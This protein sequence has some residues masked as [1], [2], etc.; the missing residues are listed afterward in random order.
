M[1][2]S[3]FEGYAFKMLFAFI[4]LLGVLA[5]ALWLVRRFGRE[6]PT[7]AGG[8]GRPARLSVIDAANVDGRR[9]LVLIRRDNL[10]HLVLIGGPSDVLIEPNIAPAGA[11]PREVPPPRHV[12]TGDTLRRAVPLGEG[13][14]WP[15]Q[16]ERGPRPEPLPRPEPQPVRPPPPATEPA[17]HWPPREPEFPQSPRTDPPRDLRG[18]IDPLSGLSEELGRAASASEPEA[19]EPPVWLTRRREPRLRHASSV[20]TPP[21]PAP[22]TDAKLGPSADQNNLAN[23]A[24]RL[25]A[26]MRRPNRKE[27]TSAPPAAPKM[28]K[29]E[30]EGEE[31]VESSSAQDSSP[32]PRASPSL[33]TVKSPRE[34]TK[35]GRN[36]GR[37]APQ[38]SLYDS[39][40]QEMASLSGRSGSKT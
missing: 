40:E 35:P 33:D 10:Q 9:K 23:T 32:A 29:P 38:K 18:R 34:E 39:L 27:G 7:N 20:V 37:P 25:E 21:I 14:M 13:N 28:E 4:V 6:R 19:S 5:L 36:E 3:L 11:T 15:L 16:P 1:L 17:A 24:Q 2:E 12:P 26:V 8:R 31:T 22:A 30:P